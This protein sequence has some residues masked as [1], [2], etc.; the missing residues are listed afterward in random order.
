MNNSR[1][2]LVSRF[3]APKDS[4]GE[5]AIHVAAMAG[6]IDALVL[7][8]EELG[9]EVRAMLQVTVHSLESY[10]ALRQRVRISLFV[11]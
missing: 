8:I 5:F 10:V 1:T 9:Q 4:E 7:L 6:S 3:S 11:A 2:L